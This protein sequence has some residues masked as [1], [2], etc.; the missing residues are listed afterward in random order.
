MPRVLANI[1]LLS[2]LLHGGN[3]LEAACPWQARACV[4]CATT[5]RPRRSC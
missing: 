3:E 2:D 1:S 5:K 4:R